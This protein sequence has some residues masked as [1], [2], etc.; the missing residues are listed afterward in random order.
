MLKAIKIRLYP[1]NNQE[2]Q[3]NKLL[4]CYRFVYNNCLALKKQKYDEN[5]ESLNLKQ[6]GDYF[7][8]TLTKSEGYSWLNEQNTK[9]LK[10]AIINMLDSYKRFFDGKGKVG[11][12]KFKS[13]Y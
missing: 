10:Q 7:H 2:V 3:I 5:K 12:P 11:F 4:G 8:N 1:N 6:L 13:K 9:V